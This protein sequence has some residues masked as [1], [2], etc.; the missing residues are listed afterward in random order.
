MKLKHITAIA[1]CAM[2]IISCDEDTSSIGI[3][4]TDEKD[5]LD[6]STKEFN[7][8]TRSIAVDSVFSRERQCYFGYVKDPE[9]K[10]YVKSEFTTQFNMMEDIEEDLPK[11]DQIVHFDNGELA[12]DSCVIYVQF[13]LS[14]C[15]GDTL[16]AMKMKVSELKKPASDVNIHYSNFDPRTAELIRE[17]GLCEQLMFSL[18]DLTMRD[19]TYTY[20][21]ARINLNEPYT[22]KSGKTH[23]NYGTYVLRSYYDH[24]E[25]F[26]NTYSY[27]NNVCP[28]FFFEIV[29]GIGVMARVK[30]IDM[31]IY[32]TA[33]YSGTE[34]GSYLRTTATEEVVQTIKVTNDKDAIRQLAEDNSCTYMKT[35]AAL[36]TEVTFPV[37]EIGISHTTD[38]LLSASVSFQRMNNKNDSPE[39][40][41]S[42]PDKVL[43]IE[44]DSLDSFF[45]GNN[46]YNNLYAF[47]VSL[48][49]NEYYFSNIS[50]LI[51]RMHNAK[52]EG[53]KKDPDWTAKHPNWNKALLVPIDEVTVNTTSSTYYYY[54]YS[55]STTTTATPIAL[56]NQMGLTSTRL[57]KGTTEKP[58]KMQIIYAKFKD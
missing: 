50:N 24:P 15:Y 38:S 19:T 47:E 57:V 31:Y 28:G 40:A 41:F 37:D 20:R 13:D 43:L 39:L 25:Y 42:V 32:Y 2:A 35:P 26:K 51:T 27:V 36:F 6:V 52:T 5:K 23:N 33:N 14:S 58:I 54:S 30:Q 49:N 34:S 21:W 16:T 12:A 11:K 29:D 7:V 53:V 55:T 48:S 18:T 4:L 22:D 9:T 56:R 17:D 10:T 44:K 1:L 8:L 3:S 45:K 46:L